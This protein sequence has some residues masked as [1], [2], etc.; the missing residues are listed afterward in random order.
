MGLRGIELRE[1][2]GHKGFFEVRCI[3]GKIS[4]GLATCEV[5]LCYRLGVAYEGIGWRSCGRV[6]LGHG[7]GD[8]DFDHRC[9]LVAPIFTI[10][11]VLGL[12]VDCSEAPMLIFFVNGAQV[13]EMVFAREVHGKLIFPVFQLRGDSEA[14]IS[15]HPDIPAH[16]GV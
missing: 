15:P 6:L 4:I 2:S 12:M 9:G 13:G 5:D 3:K 7:M 11:D 8:T 14:E 10:G 1:G 16:A